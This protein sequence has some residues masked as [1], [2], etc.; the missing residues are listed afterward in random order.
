L[1]FLRRSPAHNPTGAGRSARK[2]FQRALNRGAIAGLAAGLLVLAGLVRFAIPPAAENQPA[3]TDAIIV[4]TGGSLRLASGIDLLREGKGRVLFV[5]GVPQQVDLG[6]LLRRT[7]KDTPRWLAC[8][9]VLGHEAQNT[10][11]NAIETAHWMRREG[12]HS[13]RLVTSWYHLPRSLL[14]FGRAMPDIEII[15]H[16]VFSEPVK[17]QNWWAW[18]GT[19]ALLIGEYGKYLAALIFPMVEPPALRDFHPIETEARR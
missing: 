6:E 19:A 18:R 11:G 9:I 13:L 17:Q 8:C 12:Y 4:L 16:P 5:S 10:A 1:H 7:G 3:P 14:E 2:R 15:P